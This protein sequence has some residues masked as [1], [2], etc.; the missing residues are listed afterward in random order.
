MQNPF[1]RV[2]IVYRRT[3]MQVK[4][5]LL[6]MLVLCSLTLMTL[7]FSLMQAK[8]E[9]ETLRADAQ[10]LKQE[11][12]RLKKSISQ[13]GTVQSVTELAEQLLGLVDPNTIIFETEE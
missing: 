7:R 6:A 10:M 12:D 2:K 3:P 4:A 8:Q 11:N 13:L 1:S 5:L 9:L